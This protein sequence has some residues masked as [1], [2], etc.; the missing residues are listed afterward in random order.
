[1]NTPPPG[2]APVAGATSVDIAGAR[3]GEK[4]KTVEDVFV[5]RG[6][7]WTRATTAE[8]AAAVR[9]KAITA[10]DCEALDKSGLR[11]ALDALGLPT[12][13]KLEYM[14]TRLQRALLVDGADKTE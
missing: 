6:L 2:A 4:G 1:V 7:D 3:G 9:A 14:R 10:D 12:S 8:I 13:G 5:A 11:S